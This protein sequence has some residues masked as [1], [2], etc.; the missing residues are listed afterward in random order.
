MLRVKITCYVLLMGVAVWI[1]SRETFGKIW[2]DGFGAVNG[3][4]ALLMASLAWFAVMIVRSAIH[5]WSTHTHK[6]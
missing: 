5:D 3:I 1:G 6:S 4:D 2:V